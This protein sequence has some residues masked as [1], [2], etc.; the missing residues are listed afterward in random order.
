MKKKHAVMIGA[1]LL[2]VSASCYASFYFGQYS[3]RLTRAGTL[4]LN[5]RLYE[6]LESGDIESAKSHSVMLIY[7]AADAHALMVQS[8]AY[9]LLLNEDGIAWVTE[10]R[11]K[12]DA[13]LLKSPHTPVGFPP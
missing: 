5:V 4:P 12:A 6:A 7:I 1:A 9:P 3:E 8:K 13:I 2:I 10:S 11:A